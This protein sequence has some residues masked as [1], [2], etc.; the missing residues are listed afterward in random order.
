MNF[1]S[2]LNNI[3]KD[4][5]YQDLG[6]LNDI[7]YSS[8]NLQDLS[9]AIKKCSTKDIPDLLY[10]YEKHKNLIG[11]RF[12]AILNKRINSIKTKYVKEI[13]CRYWNDFP[14]IIL[15]TKRGWLIQHSEKTNN[16]DI[17]KSIYIFNGE[18]LKEDMIFRG[19]VRKMSDEIGYDCL[20]NTPYDVEISTEEACEIFTNKITYKVFYLD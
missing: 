5:T 15:L 17:S 12:D 18:S 13:V 6:N 8:K 16:I 20:I 2:K 1:K 19:N 7:N 14:C 4:I 3:I 9:E 10:E 11:K